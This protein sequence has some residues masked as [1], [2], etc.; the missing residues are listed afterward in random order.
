MVSQDTHNARYT[1]GQMHR[2]DPEHFYPILMQYL[3]LLV[4]GGQWM[5]EWKESLDEFSPAPAGR[6]EHPSLIY[7]NQ[8]LSSFFPTNSGMATRLGILP[9]F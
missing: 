4:N 2:S 8:Q 3:L 7:K 6:G 5:G 9:A 1:L